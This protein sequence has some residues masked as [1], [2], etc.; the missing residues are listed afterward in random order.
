VGPRPSVFYELENYSEWHR[1]RLN[2]KPGITGLWQISGRSTLTFDQMV[3]LDL[4]YIEEW[5]LWLDLSILLK[6][7]PALLRT[8]RAA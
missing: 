5:S 2:I 7:A 8:S 3:E 4:K 1:Q 6:T